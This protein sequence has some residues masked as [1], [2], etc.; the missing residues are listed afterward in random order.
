MHKIQVIFA[1]IILVV[2]YGCFAFCG[3]VKCV[4]SVKCYTMNTI[5]EYPKPKT[6]TINKKVLR[7]SCT[8]IVNGNTSCPRV[9][10]ERI[11]CDVNKEC[12]FHF[13]WN[14]KLHEWFSG[15][16]VNSTSDYTLWTWYCS[17][18]KGISVN[19]EL[20]VYLVSIISKWCLFSPISISLVRVYKSFKLV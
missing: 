13:I 10:H 4:Q 11:K 1:Y 14:R 12:N 2:I 3:K 7:Q 20:Q 15:R 8:V 16:T 9:A 18:S 5:L 17:Y 19:M 6:D